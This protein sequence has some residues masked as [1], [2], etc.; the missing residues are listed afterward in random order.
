MEFCHGTRLG[1]R[2]FGIGLYTATETLDKPV[3]PGFRVKTSQGGLVFH[4]AVKDHLSATLDLANRNSQL[5]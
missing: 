5:H 4:N 1:T 3:I 2:T